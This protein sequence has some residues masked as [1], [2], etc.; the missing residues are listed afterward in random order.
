MT[1]TEA[2]P[3]TTAKPG[4]AVEVDHWSTSLYE[5]KSGDYDH[6][7]KKKIFE[8]VYVAE[9]CIIYLAEDYSIQWRMQAGCVQPNDF[10]SI[11]GIVN[12]LEARSRFI[13]NKDILASVR[14]QIAEGLARCV[15]GTP[16]T[17]AMK[18]LREA[19]IEIGNRN[20]ETSWKW[21]FSTASGLVAICTLAILIFW[22]QRV[23]LR[24]KF[25]ETGFEIVFGSLCGSIGAIL[26]I[27]ARG[28]RLHLDANAGDWIH[29]MEAISRIGA[30]L[31]GAAFVATAIKSG[32]LLG[33]VNF[34]GSPFSLLLAFCMAAGM[35]ERLIPNLVNKIDS[36]I[37]ESKN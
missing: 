8:V 20:K 31:A 32:L 21:Y 26:S 33:G 35:S 15:D 11:L 29:R 4:T 19:D 2:N 3:I 9:K 23:Y 18:L 7:L 1:Q 17:E 28:D 37:D 25:G 16:T 36:A 14:K 5:L 12:L 24:N 30:G 27:A 34:A 22:L 6:A 10:N 13:E